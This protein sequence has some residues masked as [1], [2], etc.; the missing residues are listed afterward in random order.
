MK[1]LWNAA[2]LLL[3]LAPL[4]PVYA[5]ECSIQSILQAVYGASHETDPRQSVC[6]VWP[7]RPDITLVAAA[8]NR[9]GEE[10]FITEDLE[11]LMIETTSNK[12]LAR[13]Y[14]PHRLDADTVRVE[15]LMF[16]T[17]PYALNDST[18]AFGLR[19]SRKGLSR[20][21][22]QYE[23]ALSLYVPNADTLIPVLE[24]LQIE[25][26]FGEWDTACAGEFSDATGT[27]AMGKEVSH[28]YR[29]LVLRQKVHYTR[30]E[31]QSEEECISAEDT[32]DTYR[33]AL[34]F[35]GN[36]YLIPKGLTAF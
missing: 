9:Q 32:T 11:V 13:R 16:D 36:R 34:V 26:S 12:V 23:T 21:N 33:Y 29:S 14:E 30:Q 2:G 18:L 5:H 20:A 10:G 19:V 8:L 35:N 6:K 24:N 28:G 27:I 17:A 31:A 7:A 4:T 25:D 3:L 1:H 22:P 15:G